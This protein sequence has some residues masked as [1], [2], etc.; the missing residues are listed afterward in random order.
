MCH[1]LHQGFSYLVPFYWRYKFEGRVTNHLMFPLYAAIT[2]HTVRQP[3]GGEFA[4]DAKML[5]SFTEVDR[6]SKGWRDFGIDMGMTITAGTSGRSIGQVVLPRKINYVGEDARLQ[7][8]DIFVQAGRSL[9]NG[10]L[11]FIESGNNF[12]L[13]E[14]TQIPTVEIEGLRY[15]NNIKEVANT[16]ANSNVKVELSDCTEV[17]GAL[18]KFVTLFTSP[19]FQSDKQVLDSFSNHLEQA[20]AKLKENDLCSIPKLNSLSEDQKSAL[21]TKIQCLDQSVFLTAKNW[22]IIVFKCFEIFQIRRRRNEE[23]AATEVIR[24]VLLCA[25]YLRV[26]SFNVQTYNLPTYPDAEDLLTQQMHEFSK[27]FEIGFPSVGEV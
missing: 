21:L 12:K 18:S 25:F 19:A 24:N 4:F 17:L 16:N 15:D 8:G 2:R 22:A 26:F 3:I 10:L 11:D 6:W 5:E 27:R 1:G 20:Y 13:K 7:I 14:V 23:N 9:F